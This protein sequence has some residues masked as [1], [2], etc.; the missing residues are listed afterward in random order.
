MNPLRL[1][2]WIGVTDRLARFSC[3]WSS[4]FCPANRRCDSRFPALPRHPITQFRICTLGTAQTYPNRH[5]FQD[6]CRLPA[7][8]RVVRGSRG[9]THRSQQAT[10]LGRSKFGKPNC[11]PGGWMACGTF[12]VERAS[13][14]ESNALQV[15]I[16]GMPRRLAKECPK[17]VFTMGPVIGCIKRGRDVSWL[18]CSQGVTRTRRPKTLRLP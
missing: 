4:P 14:R 15:E 5:G 16:L 10:I 2:V 12:A 1:G 9:L 8:P 11:L 3:A 6:Q 18:S 7:Q 17:C 13:R